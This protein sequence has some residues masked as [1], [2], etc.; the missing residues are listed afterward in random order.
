MKTSMERFVEASRNLSDRERMIL[1]EG[2]QFA[3]YEEARE[4]SESV[5]IAAEDGSIHDI[6]PL[7]EYQF[8]ILSNLDKSDG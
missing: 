3:K 4:A 7:P 8:S 5:K 6:P 1:Y 2:Y